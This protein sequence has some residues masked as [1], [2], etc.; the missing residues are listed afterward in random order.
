MPRKAR[1]LLESLF[2]HQMCQ[3]FNREYIFEERVEKLKY[4]SLMKKY[5]EKFDIDIIAYCIMDNHVH[6]LLYAKNINDISCFM[7]EVNSQYA[8]YYNR[9]KNRV[10]Y[11]FRNRFTSKAII[12]KQQLLAC[13][14]YIHMNPVKAKMVENEEEYYFSSYQ[15]Y[16]NPKEFVNSNNFSIVFNSDKNYLNQFHSIKYENL[17][18]D[19]DDISLKDILNEFIELEK[20]YFEQVRKDIILFQRFISYIIYREY[21]YTKPELAEA[22]QLS[23]ATVYRRLNAIKTNQIF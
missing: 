11:V 21:N 22:L 14:K 19:K 15:E 1:N 5:Q 13:I 9:R 10:G 12:N 20:V 23:K 16:N 4:L 8:M 18:F 3:G 17:N 2:I 7:K 6:M